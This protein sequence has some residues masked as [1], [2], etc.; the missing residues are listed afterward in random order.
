MLELGSVSEKAHYE[1]GK[2][3]AENGIDAVFT[4][5]ERALETARGAADGNV[6][7]VKSF[8]DKDELSKELAACLR[9]DD[10]VLFKTSRGMKLEDVIYSVYAALEK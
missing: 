5:G 10:A 1:V 9:A 6:P 7:C 3:A 2:K 8:K 4:Y